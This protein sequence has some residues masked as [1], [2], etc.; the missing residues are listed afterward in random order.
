M[1]MIFQEK[2]E[3][4][5][6]TTEANWHLFQTVS[7]DSK[8]SI[9]WPISG[10]SILK[11]YSL[12]FELHL[13]EKHVKTRW[14]KTAPMY[15]KLSYIWSTTRRDRDGALIEETQR[16]PLVGTDRNPKKPWNVFV[17]KYWTIFLIK[18]ILFYWYTQFQTHPTHSVKL[19]GRTM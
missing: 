14:I 3:G 17:W 13:H 2:L 10:K 8:S 6:G 15:A 4:G 16:V 12:R 5:L 18:V 1:T 9:D 19:S 11:I 7:M